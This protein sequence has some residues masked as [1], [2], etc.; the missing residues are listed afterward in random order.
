MKAIIKNNISTIKVKGNECTILEESGN[1]YLV[2]TILNG[3]EIKLSINKLNVEIS[4][5]LTLI[6][7]VRTEKLDRGIQDILDF[8]KD[9]EARGKGTIIR[10][11]FR[12]IPNY[13]WEVGNYNSYELS[14]NYDRENG[15]KVL[16]WLTLEKDGSYDLDIS[17]L[18]NRKIA[19]RE[20]MCITKNECRN[21]N[22]INHIKNEILVSMSNF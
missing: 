13:K 14:F 15:V 6:N 4:Q 18:A 17:L 20:I 21:Y 5:E 11:K 12:I 8:V 7:E 1:Q 22:N 9:M 16:Y 2:S 10:G 19:G 3:K